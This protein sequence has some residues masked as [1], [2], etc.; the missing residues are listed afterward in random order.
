[1]S[2]T[3]H[4]FYTLNILPNLYKMEVLQH[5]IDGVYE[6]V[7]KLFGDERGYFFESFNPIITETLGVDFVQENQSYSMP[8]VIRGLHYQKKPYGQG[9]LVKVVMGIVDDVI[10]DLREESKTYGEHLI[11]NLDSRKSNMLYVPEG[12]AHGFVTRTETIF[13][14]KCTNVYN[15]ESEG[16]IIWNDPNLNIDWGIENPLVSEKDKKL[17]KL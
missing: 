7:P 17:P 14:Y 13:Q 6:F 1:V 9:K 15:K 8:N 11:V 4:L 5:K 12:F 10:V 16:G 3:T 2:K